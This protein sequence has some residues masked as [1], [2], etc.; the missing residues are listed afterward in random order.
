MKRYAGPDASLKETSICIVDGMGSVCREMKAHSISWILPV[1]YL[2][3]RRHAFL[4]FWRYFH[5]S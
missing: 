2:W 4:G 5:E 1:C 3:I